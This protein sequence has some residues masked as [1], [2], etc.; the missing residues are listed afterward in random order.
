ML[1]AKL[2][3]LPAA[4]AS[5]VTV[6]MHSVPS[7]SSPQTA[8]IPSPIPLVQISYDADQTTGT[9]VSYTPPQGSYAS[10]HLLRIGLHDTKA[11]TWKGILTSAASFAEEYKKKFVVHVDEK[12]EPYHVGF[13]TS[14]KGAGEG[15]ELEVEVV[16]REV[17][18]KPVLNKPVVLNA[19]GRIDSKEP[20]KTFI[21]KYW[22]MIAIFLVVQLVAGG[23]KE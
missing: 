14:V 16:R 15:D 23:G 19:D 4:V 7:T 10:D 3:L 11:G 8:V 9:V 1:L 18:P 5:S 17:G 20:E 13:S 2:F 12:G 6:Y 22:W 21:Q